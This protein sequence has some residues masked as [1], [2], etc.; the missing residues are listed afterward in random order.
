MDLHYSKG[1]VTGFVKVRNGVSS[2]PFL[3]TYNMMT[4]S[5]Y[6]IQSL[7]SQTNPLFR[8]FCDWNCQPSRATS[9]SRRLRL[10]KAI[11]EISTGPPGSLNMT[12]C[13]E[14]KKLQEIASV[15]VAILCAVQVKSNLID[16]QL[17]TCN[18]YLRVE[19]FHKSSGLIK[20]VCHPYLN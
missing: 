20:K 11:L 5:K 10:R 12:S 4:S 19:L 18:S 9:I 15:W 2:T 17:I 7:G 14:K 6:E 16:L 8:G 1:I 13:W 3:T